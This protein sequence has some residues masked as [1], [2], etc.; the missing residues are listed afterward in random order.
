MGYVGPAS[1][2]RALAFLLVAASAAT[3]DRGAAD[4]EAQERIR[5]LGERS[6]RLAARYGPDHRKLR[7]R[8]IVAGASER[9][10]ERE[11]RPLADAGPVWTSLGPTETDAEGSSDSGMTGALALDPRDPATLYAGPAGGGV[12]KTTDRGASW[13]PLTDDVGVTEIGALAVAPSAP[14]TL[15]AGTGIGRTSQFSWDGQ[16]VGLLASTDAGRTWRITGSSPADDFFAISV[17]PRDSRVLLVAGNRG[18]QRSTDGGETFQQTLQA[19]GNPWANSIVRSPEDPS[20]VHAA[21]FAMG[22][23]CHRSRPV[24]GAIWKSTDGGLTWAEK[25]AGLPTGRARIELA[26]AASRPDTLYASIGKSAKGSSGCATDLGTTLAIVRSTDGGE[27]WVDLHAPSDL[28]GTQ[29]CYA[30]AISVSPRSPDTVFVGGLFAFRSSDGGTTWSRTPGALHVD[31]QVHLQAP[32]GTLYVGNDGGVF[33]STDGGT[34]YRSL[35]RGLVT[36][37]YYTLCQS[38]ADP[39]LVLGGTQDNGT[40]LRRSGTAWSRVLGGDGI[41]CLVHPTDPRILHASIYENRIYR[42]TDGGVIF[43]RSTSGLLDSGNSGSRGDTLLRRRPSNPDHLYSASARRLW[44]STDDGRTWFTR[45]GY[46]PDVGLIGDFDLDPAGGPTLVVT[47][48]QGRLLV[49]PDAGQTFEARAT[50]M[51]ANGPSRVR[52]HPLDPRIVY[53]STLLPGADRQRLWMS[54]DSGATWAALSHHGEP[55][56][57][58]DFPIE[59]IAPDPI[60][61]T[62]IW[63]GTYIGLYRSTDGRRWHRYGRGLPNASVQ[64][65]AFLPGGGDAWK[66]RVATYGRGIWE[67][68]RVPAPPNGAP[69]ASILEPS[70]PVE[71]GIP[72]PFAGTGTDPDPGDALTYRWSFGDGATAT[73][74]SVAHAYAVPGTYHVTLTATDPAGATGRAERDVAVRVPTTAGAGPERLLPVVLDVVGFAGARYTTELTIASRADGPVDA[75]LQYTASLGAGSGFASL[76]LAPREQRVVPDAIA[77]LREQGLPIPPDG[78]AQVGTL[79]VVFLG[80]PE[81]S[82]FVGARTSTPGAGGT[83]GLFYGPALTTGSSA[84]L[85]GLQESDTQRSNVAL[86]NAGAGPVTLRL[87]LSGPSGESLG[88]LPDQTL[89]GYG[90]TQVDRPLQGK[91]PSGRAVVTRIAG[92]S[93]FSAY[94]VLNDAVTSDGSYVPPLFP[95]LPGGA[96]RLVPIVLDV[97]GLGGTRFTTELTLAN[98]GASALELGLVYVAA[99]SLGGGVGSGQVTVRLPAGEQRII[100]DSIALLRAAGLSI[101]TGTSVGGSLLVRAPAGTPA[102]ELAVGARTFTPA[103]GGG[104]FGLYYPGLTLAESAPGAATIGGLQQGERQRSNFAIVN[105]GDRGDP[106]TLR[107]TLFG[108][109]GAPLGSPLELTLAPGE[110]R[111]LG[112]PLGP[113]AETSGYA[114]VEKVSGSSRFVAYG[115]L[116]DAATSDGSYVPMSD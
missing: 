61:A 23:Y 63:A 111:Q 59:S 32:D 9:R 75:L 89:E 34:T 108:A 21:T 30:N 18:L 43:D 49:S 3:P 25:S 81:G 42:S 101:P 112:Q 46:L 7:L 13:T 26:L 54:R 39:G 65:L 6:R 72:H 114:R 104:T 52:L 36:M 99:P 76:R 109:S 105:R 95:D 53:V 64:A 66:V 86:V 31:Q 44:E 115:V 94:A 27:S 84:T 62:T 71:A 116:N 48:Y 83:F 57:L 15:Y 113:Y 102:S 87:S 33:S 1:A 4:G 106:I 51:P 90:W 73:G 11:R 96:D 82:V 10:L 77:F 19:P 85:V 41:E 50:P 29:A 55:D 70:G 22:Y 79:R 45:S 38:P 20:I 40:V 74:A 107:V 16:G 68:P 69:T 24:E 93:P 98:L 110:W 67:A 103:A 28:L 58:P 100:P 12:W 17:D 14:D 78:S 37:Q 2:L 97:A 56:G 8:A 92:D 60:D 88:T 5:V 35:N 47:D 91:A 80:A